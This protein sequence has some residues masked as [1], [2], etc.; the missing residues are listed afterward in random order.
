MAMTRMVSSGAPGNSWMVRATALTQ[1]LIAAS[2]RPA[3]SLISTIGIRT[4]RE[5]QS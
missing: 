3:T 2:S 1:R 5:I 4:S